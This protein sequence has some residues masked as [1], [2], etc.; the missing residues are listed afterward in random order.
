MKEIANSTVIVGK[1]FENLVT[2]ILRQQGFNVISRNYALHNVGEIDIIAILNKKIYFIETRYRKTAN[3]GSSMDSIRHSKISKIMAT[4]AY[5]LRW[6]PL[7]RSYTKHF[8]FITNDI[9]KK[10]GLRIFNLR[11]FIFL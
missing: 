8:L 9:T 7:Y 5:F 4:A 6:N 11:C 2:G 10:N 1:V 3:L